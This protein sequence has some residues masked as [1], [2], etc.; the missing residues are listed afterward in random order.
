MNETEAIALTPAGD[1][2]WEGRGGAEDNGGGIAWAARASGNS[3]ASGFGRLRSGR[4][5]PKTL[6]YDEVIY[7][8]QGTFGV[9]CNGIDTVARVG[10]VLSIKRGSTVT[11]FG[12]EAQFFFVVT[13]A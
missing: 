3:L 9:S 10:G 7:V 2:Q 5:P 11:Y 8:L 6:G 4:T 1:V 12:T 13:A